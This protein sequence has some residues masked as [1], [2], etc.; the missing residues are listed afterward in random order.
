MA[1]RRFKRLLIIM[2][3]LTLIVPTIS[4]KKEKENKVKQTLGEKI[5]EE[6]Q[7]VTDFARDNDFVYGHAS[8]NPGYNWG[9]L[10]VDKALNRGERLTS[11]DRLIDWVLYRTGFTD[12]PYNN[13]LV[14]FQQPAWLESLNFEKITDI[15]ALQ[16]GDIVFMKHD[17]TRPGM[18]G[19]V[20]ICASENLGGNVYLRY[21]HGSNERIKCVKG[22]EVKKG[23]QPFKEG[24]GEFYYAYRPNDSTLDVDYADKDSNGG[25]AINNE[26]DISFDIPYGSAKIDGKI[27]EKE[28]KLSYKMDKSNCIPWSGISG[29]YG[30]EIYMSWDESGLY[31]AAEIEDKSPSYKPE[32]VGWVGVDCLQLGVNPGNIINNSKQGIFFTLGATSDG[33][34]IASRHNYNE[35]MITD[36]IQGVATDHT[37]GK[38]S[39]II[40]VLIPWE[41]IIFKTNKDG[42]VDTTAF[43]PK[44]GAKINVLPCVIDCKEDGSTVNCAYKFKNTDFYVAN[45]VPAKL[46][47]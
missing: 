11:C 15:S 47:K 12:Q 34:V 40:E 38:N 43:K 24:I 46:S 5:C 33:K 13:G 29:L 26:I 22:T 20:F 39:Y 44:K 1:L 18:P 2:V 8:I 9:E 7:K 17:P 10:D 21:D 36:K 42:T 23:Q 41:E 6:A 27:E 32:N 35:E 3:I 16:P 19:H 45:F 30:A 4:C 31:Y 25:F 28:Y 14:V 37:K